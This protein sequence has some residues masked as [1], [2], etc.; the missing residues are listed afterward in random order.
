MII[1][2]MADEEQAAIV[3]KEKQ[4]KV[5]SSAVTNKEHITSLSRG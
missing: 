5:D 4:A 3:M 1:A 2:M